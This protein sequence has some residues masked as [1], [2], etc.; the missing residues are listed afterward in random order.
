MAVAVAVVACAAGATTGVRAQSHPETG[1]QAQPAPIRPADLTAA[2]H[3][4]RAAAANAKKGVSVWTFSAVR[5]ALA[6]SGAS[7]YYTWSV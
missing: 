1:R 3:G 7:W 6:R 2:E 4:E 5:K